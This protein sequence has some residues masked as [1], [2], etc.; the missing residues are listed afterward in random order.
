MRVRAIDSNSRDKD[1]V[2]YKFK[3]PFNI[4]EIQLIN[5]EDY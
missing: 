2:P 4:S 1:N 3:N 5:Y